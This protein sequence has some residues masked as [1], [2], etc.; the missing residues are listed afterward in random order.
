MISGKWQTAVITEKTM[1]LIPNTFGIDSLSA[2]DFQT[3]K[4]WIEQGYPQN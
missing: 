2:D 1:P 4:C 3:M